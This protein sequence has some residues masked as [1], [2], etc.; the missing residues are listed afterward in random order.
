MEK[1]F[2]LVFEEASGSGGDDLIIIKRM[3]EESKS[4]Y[5]A[6]MVRRVIFHTSRPLFL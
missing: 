4:P 3:L 2:A 6:N 1:L 5:H